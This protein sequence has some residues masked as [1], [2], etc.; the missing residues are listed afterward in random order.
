[1]RSA[2]APLSVRAQMLPEMLVSCFVS[3]RICTISSIRPRQQ[4]REEGQSLA[5]R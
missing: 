3:G 4:Q 1:M 2:L 5:P